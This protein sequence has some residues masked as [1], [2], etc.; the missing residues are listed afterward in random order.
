VKRFQLPEQIRP[1][2]EARNALKERYLAV[3]LHFTLDGNLVGD[4]GEAV[5]AELFGVKLT[6]RSNE[7]IDGYA[8]DGRSVQV[9]ASGTRRGPAFRPT[10]TRADHLLFFHFDYDGCAGEVVYNG[11]EEPVVRTLPAVWTGQRCV[12]VSML[13]R[14]DDQVD[15]AS[16]LPM[17]A[18]PH[19]IG[20]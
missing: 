10:E 13:R 8:V 11:P 12:S 19:S 3:D 7:G 14:L 5:A 2:I 16:R 18:Q 1:L 17:I 6:G 15:H 20:S 4:L 9:K